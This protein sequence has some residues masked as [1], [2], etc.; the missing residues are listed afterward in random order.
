PAVDFERFCSDNL[1]DICRRWVGYAKENDAQHPVIIDSV[2]GSLLW[3][4]LTDANYNDFDIADTCDIFGGTFYP[5]SWGQHFVHSWKLPLCYALSSGA[6]QKVGKPFYINELQTHTQSALTPGSE[7]SPDEL[8]GW[9]WSGL[10]SGAKGIQL[11]R[12]RPFLHGYQATGRGLTAMNGDPGPRAA[13][14]KT[15]VNVLR[16]HEPLF[17]EARPVSPVVKLVVS[18]RSR[19]F[20][21]KL[22]FNWPDSAHAAAI[23]GWFRMFWSSGIP[24]AITELER[25][26]DDDLKTPVLVLPSL[27]SCSDLHRKQLERYVKSGGRL[28]ADARLGAIDEDGVV[29]S[30]GIPGNVFSRV[31][32]LAERDVD[33]AVEF[34]FCK[35]KVKGSF[36]SQKLDLAP[37]ANVLGKTD[38]GEPVAVEHQYGQGVSLYFAAFMGR[39]W[40]EK[41]TDNQRQFFREFVLKAAPGVPWAEKSDSVNVSF[42]YGQDRYLVYAVNMGNTEENVRFHNVPADDHIT[43]IVTSSEL[44]GGQV[45]SVNVPARQTRVFGL[46]KVRRQ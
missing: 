11:W 7:V 26:D 36:L 29:C 43:E 39:T 31:F 15:L 27:I 40:Q 17:T 28:I 41:I 14:V 4:R 37:A 45:V 24:M 34:D 33:G 32:G 23:E 8:S 16:R 3:D 10:A 46:E 6:A 12:W 42:H 18:Y 20:Y 30:E 38:G 13:S 21:D 25:L 2:A 5:K 9:I 19:L 22:R 35:E 1:T 44:P